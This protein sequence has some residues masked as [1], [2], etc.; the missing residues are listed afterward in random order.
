ML[1]RNP[2][3]HFLFISIFCSCFVA[4]KGNDTHNNDSNN[5]VSP[6]EFT[7]SDSIAF[8]NLPIWNTQD[9]IW[10]SMIEPFYRQRKFQLQWFRYNKL[11]EQT[12]FLIQ[13][14][15]SNSNKNDTILIHE[16]EA[17]NA[18]VFEFDIEFNTIE[19]L[20]VDVIYSI[21]F[22]KYLHIIN[23]AAIVPQSERNKL[24]WN[25]YSPN[26]D[27]MKLLDDFISGNERKEFKR[28]AIYS[29]YYKL[30]SKLNDFR[31]LEKN[32]VWPHLNSQNTS[33]AIGDSDS[34]VC[35]A[36]L[37]L[38][39]LGY[40]V[41][42]QNSCYLDSL[43]SITLQTFQRHNGIKESGILDAKT[44]EILNVTPAQRIG[45]IL[46]N[47][48]RCKWLPEEPKGK[49]IA[50]NIPDFKL[51]VYDNNKLQWSC[52]VVVGR[53]TSSTVIFNNTLS[54]VVFSP[55]W[56]IPRSIL[57]NE[58]LPKVKN[59]PGY[60][61]RQNM[62]VYNSNGQVMAAD[63][64]HWAQYSRNNFPYSIRQKPGPGNA[65]GKVK[66]LFPNEHN[67]Y[68]HDTPAK[69]LFSE[70]I[71]AF[72]HG[73]IRVQSPAKLAHFLLKDESDAWDIEK[74]NAA[75]LR[76]NEFTVRLANAV[77]VFIAYFTAWVDRDGNLHF[78]D[79]IYGHDEKL[80][81]ILNHNEP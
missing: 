75:M 18:K 32:H 49:Y 1:F 48:E 5:Q 68:L 15:S 38:Q 36:R 61:H 46:V 60:L 77:P 8:E 45:Q 81:Q 73:C 63:Q 52:N 19:A 56:N 28:K 78:R 41:S 27:F 74:V 43:F 26:P 59:D 2:I 80:L 35:N 11:T 53:K 20:H 14:V 24:G 3:Y 67:I 7:F 17:L 25:I 69:N 42:N 4:C 55:Y 44:I 37:I 62:E 47:M 6:E 57:V 23:Y 31:K 34:I 71:R 10:K 22:C 70:P 9:S 64:I 66:F 65:L 40:S 54:M 29:Q 13:W 51:L 58:I 12:Q 30:K 72:S 21:L 33:L 16:L 50:V 76:K 39:Y 79:D